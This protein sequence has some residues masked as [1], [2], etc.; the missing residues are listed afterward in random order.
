MNFKVNPNTN[1]KKLLG[2]L[3]MK[4]LK[5][6]AVLTAVYDSLTRTEEEMIPSDSPSE[7]LKIIS[8]ISQL[9]RAELDQLYTKMTQKQ[10]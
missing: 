2:Q 10:L 9:S 3:K 4:A 1:N 6:E 7:I 5:I 8:T